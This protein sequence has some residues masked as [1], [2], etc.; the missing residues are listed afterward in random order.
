MII[1]RNPFEYFPIVWNGKHVHPRAAAVAIII[2][3][4]SVKF[5]LP[6]EESQSKLAEICSDVLK[7]SLCCILRCSSLLTITY[8]PVIYASCSSEILKPF[9]AWRADVLTSWKT[10]IYWWLLILTNVFVQSANTKL[11]FPG[12]NNSF[13]SWFW[14]AV[15][16]CE[17]ILLSSI[18]D[19][20]VLEIYI[21]FRA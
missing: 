9:I 8:P 21:E 7:V 14:K 4:M 16:V 13:W 10:K 2:K 20:T 6:A 18:D 11:I 5:F 15:T 3:A 12:T 19:E 17:F 1:A